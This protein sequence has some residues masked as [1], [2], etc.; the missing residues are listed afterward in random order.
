MKLENCCR[1]V[2]SISQ[3]FRNASILRMIC[4]DFSTE[5]ASF[6]K[7]KKGNLAPVLK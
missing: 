7:G 6:H 1:I 4:K 3:C 5:D 2:V